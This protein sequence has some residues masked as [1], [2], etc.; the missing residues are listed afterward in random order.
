MAFLVVPYRKKEIA[1]LQIKFPGGTNKENPHEPPVIT[2]DRELTEETGLTVENWRCI[3][4]REIQPDP[5]R[6]KLELHTQYYYLMGQSG[7]S[8]DLREQKIVEEDGEILYPP[9]WA[10]AE[11]LMYSII[12]SHQKALFEAS[13]IL[14][15]LNAEVG[16]A[17]HSLIRV[18]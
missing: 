18:A 16:F 1:P 3:H 7:Y 15:R 4:T 17:L 12:P 11:E 8:G 13:K 6:G 14:G 9:I 5:E 2:R 10:D